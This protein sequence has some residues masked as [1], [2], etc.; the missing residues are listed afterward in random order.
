M[1]KSELQNLHRQQNHEADSNRDSSGLFCDGCSVAFNGVVKAFSIKCFFVLI[2]T[3]SVLVSGVFWILP[4]HSTKF[5]FEAKDE[6]KLSGISYPCSSY[7]VWI[8]KQVDNLIL[9]FGVV[10]VS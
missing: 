7:V 3:L 2:L 6:I 10:R 1:G 8:F 9:F 4:F 5:G